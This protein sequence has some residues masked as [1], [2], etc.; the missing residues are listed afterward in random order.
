[1]EFTRRIVWKH[2]RATYAVTLTLREL[3]GR[4]EPVSIAVEPVLRP[5]EEPRVL[6]SD[7]LR[8]LPVQRLV[9]QALADARLIAEEAQRPLP[10][11][12]GPLPVVESRVEFDE[13]TG[14][15]VDRSTTA[16]GP[17]VAVLDEEFHANRERFWQEQRERAARMQELIRATGEGNGRRWGREHYEQVL[18]V[19]EEAQI[20]RQSTTRAVAEAFD[21]TDA[22][23]LKHIE[24]AKKLRAASSRA[25]RPSRQ[26]RRRES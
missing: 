4:L 19:Y 7:L 1:M 6:T 16:A 18:E 3:N 13:S 10:R 12:G 11:L 23:A 5:K 14:R 25:R 24:R 17:R 2:E 21:L 9:T 15:Y 8:R 22:T 20:F 26:R